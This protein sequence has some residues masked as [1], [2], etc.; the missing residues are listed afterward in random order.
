MGSLSVSMCMIVVILT[1]LYFAKSFIHLPFRFSLPLPVSNFCFW[2]LGKVTSLS[3]PETPPRVE[4]RIGWSVSL[5]LDGVAF[6]FGETNGRLSPHTAAET[7]NAK[8]KNE[9]PSP[10]AGL[11]VEA[12]WLDIVRL[13]S[14]AFFGRL[15]MA[16]VGVPSLSLEC[17]D[18]DLSLP[19]EG[20]S[21][22]EP[23]GGGRGAHRISESLERQRRR[24]LSLAKF[25]EG[26]PCEIT[27]CVHRLNV[28]RGQL[29]GRVTELKLRIDPHN[30]PTVCFLS[31]PLT[32]QIDTRDA[33][34]GRVTVQLERLSVSLEGGA[35][36]SSEEAEESHKEE[37]GS[38]VGEG[39]AEFCTQS[40]GG[41]KPKE[42]ERAYECEKKLRE[43]GGVGDRDRPSGGPEAEPDFSSSDHKEAENAAVSRGVEKEEMATEGEEEQEGEVEG[44]WTET[45][46]ESW[47]HLCLP[48]FLILQDFTA[49]SWLSSKEAFVLRSTRVQC[50]GVRVNWKQEH[51]DHFAQNERA[52]RG[53]EESVSMQFL[54][55]LPD[56]S[57]S[58]TELELSVKGQV[59]RLFAL[60]VY[61]DLKETVLRL[62]AFKGSGSTDCE[63]VRKFYADWISSRWQVLASSS[64]GRLSVLEWC[65][66][67]GGGSVGQLIGC[68]QTSREAIGRLVVLSA[69]AVRAA[70]ERGWEER[71]EVNFKARGLTLSGPIA[72]FGRGAVLLASDPRSYAAAGVCVSKAAE[73]MMWSVVCSV[74]GGVVG[75]AV[76][77]PLGGFVGM[78]VGPMGSGFVS[79]MAS[80]WHRAMMGEKGGAG[81]GREGL[82]GQR[83]DVDG[84]VQGKGNG[85]EWSGMGAREGERDRNL[86]Q[87]QPE[88]DRRP[89]IET[90]RQGLP[91]VH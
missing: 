84:N 6:Q 64:V 66:Q 89:Q 39:E 46:S 48:P 68:C 47:T 63:T 62:P 43:G 86:Q 81:E 5:F 4:I 17:P 55:M 56:L 82:G 40:E 90:E 25:V 76:G 44:A 88:R 52:A 71:Q 3:F 41:G 59:L 19:S 45:E 27:V 14:C 35:D 16:L 11:V 50:G 54:L 65:L 77:G 91:Q 26:V 80:K 85:S 83:E 36:G 9:T 37:D 87:E 73:G 21:G 33:P 2:V 12:W 60:P 69:D 42:A 70:T 30:P 51:S 13:I 15:G 75:T 20:S 31:A 10:P 23:E 61:L 74:V 34:S 78:S 28:N 67:A 8:E 72:D 18:L 57:V 7:G 38:A 58:E 29:L 22:G 24:W 32:R 1:A 49:V 79:K 53:L